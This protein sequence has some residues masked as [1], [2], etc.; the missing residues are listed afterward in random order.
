VKKA[1]A[2]LTKIASRD[3]EHPMEIDRDEEQADERSSEYP[4]YL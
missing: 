3:K 1:A 4:L 2:I